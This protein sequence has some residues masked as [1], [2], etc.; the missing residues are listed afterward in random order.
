MHVCMRSSLLLLCALLSPALASAAAPA[1]QTLLPPGNL[2]GWDYVTSP[3]ADIA[4]VCTWKPGGV[5]AIA[6]KPV[7]YLATKT[8]HKNFRLH[9]EWRWTDKPGN[10]GVLIHIVGGPKDRQWPECFQVQTKNKSAGD[11]LPMAGATFAEP[12]TSAP[13]A[14]PA[15]RAHAAPD[16]EKPVGEWNTCDI[17]CRGDA[18]EV[19]INGVAQNKVTGCSLREGKIGF[20]LEGVAYELRNVTLEELK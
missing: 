3:A 6:G 1:A 14:N 9:A 17:T 8:A 10:S 19:A 2:A 20:Q 15:L 16:S 7:G 11:L 12:L 5:L 13:G 18:I 4:T